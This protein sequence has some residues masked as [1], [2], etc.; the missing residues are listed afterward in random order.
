MKRPDGMDF[1]KF[2]KIRSEMNRRLRI[3]LRGR[4]TEQKGFETDKP[5]RKDRREELFHK[6]TK[7]ERQARFNL[8][9][10]EKEINVK[11]K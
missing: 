10:K 3:Y 5:N 6:E 9:R 4:F 11:N 8:M 2:R 1:E 7:S